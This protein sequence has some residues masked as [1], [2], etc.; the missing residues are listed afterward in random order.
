MKGLLSISVPFIVWCMVYFYFAI[1]QI[2]LIVSY[3]VVYI[4][5]LQCYHIWD[6]YCAGF[7]MFE[8]EVDIDGER[9]KV[10]LWYAHL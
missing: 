7:D 3:C 5:V 1:G 8:K 9:I 4:A 10:Y 6:Y 2:V